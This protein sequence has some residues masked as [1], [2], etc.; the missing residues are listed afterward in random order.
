MRTIGWATV[1]EETESPDL[2]YVRLSI[3]FDTVG[4]QEWNELDGNLRL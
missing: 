4:I 1:V 2:L 3:R